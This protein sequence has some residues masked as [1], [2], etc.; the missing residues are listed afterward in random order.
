[1][2]REDFDLLIRAAADVVQDELVVVGSQAIL[3]QF[4]DAPDALLRSAEVDLYP[5]GAPKR[6]STGS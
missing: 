1:M 2:K 3:A 6:A 4:P 5:R